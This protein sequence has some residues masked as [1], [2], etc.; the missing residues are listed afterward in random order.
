[1]EKGLKWWVSGAKKLPEK[2][3]LEDGY[4]PILSSNV[5]DPPSVGVIWK[6]QESAF[7]LILTFL[8]VFVSVLLK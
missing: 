7:Y 8:G 6:K 5:S 2:G 4:V 1:M 3:G